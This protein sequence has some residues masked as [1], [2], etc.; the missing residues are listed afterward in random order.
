MKVVKVVFDYALL[1]LEPMETF[2]LIA[3]ELPEIPELEPFWEALQ[4]S[5]I[6]ERRRRR[7]NE[8]GTVA[9]RTVIIPI[10]SLSTDHLEYLGRTLVSFTKAMAELRHHHM[11]R[12][13]EA[14]CHAV[15]DELRG[16]GEAMLRQSLH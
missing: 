6:R 9:A 1:D 7:E 14:V 12:F 15:A 5:F 10:E 8:H 2:G 13:F 11:A 4:A 16:K 3:A